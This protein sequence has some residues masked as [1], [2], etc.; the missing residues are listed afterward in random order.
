MRHALLHLHAL[1]GHDAFRRGLVMHL[2][3]RWAWNTRRD[4]A[5]PVMPAAGAC[6]FSGAHLDAGNL[7]AT[8]DCA[9][10]I[11][12]FAAWDDTMR[13]TP[14]SAIVDRIDREPAGDRRRR[15]YGYAYMRSR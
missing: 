3:R 10:V 14:R 5:R 7:A 1:L 4:G 11:D 6:Q 2:Y 12:A 9:T 15:P 13:R 8:R